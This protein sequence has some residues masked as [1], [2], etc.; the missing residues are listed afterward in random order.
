[1]DSVDTPVD[2]ELLDAASAAREANKSNRE[3]AL[4]RMD[5]LVEW[6]VTPKELRY[7]STKKDLA[8]A[9]GVSQETLRKYEQDA[10]TRRE[11][12]KRSRSVFTVSRASDVIETLYQRATD[13]NDPQGVTAA[14]T[15]MQFMETQDRNDDPEAVDLSSMSKDDLVALALRVAGSE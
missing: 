11:Y 10:W 14:R 6:L 9:L 4:A 15:L 5:V 8:A 3:G 2:T 1:M 7:P 13:P 12:L